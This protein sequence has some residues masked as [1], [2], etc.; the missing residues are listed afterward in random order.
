MALR[1]TANVTVAGVL[2]G[3]GDTLPPGG[4]DAG[5]LLRLG[6]AEEI[7]AAKPKTKPAGG[8]G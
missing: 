5:R 7:K 2:Y 4:V 6:V 8:E 1:A 3:P